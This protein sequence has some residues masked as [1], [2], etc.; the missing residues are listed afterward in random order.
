[1]AGYASGGGP[2]PWQLAMGFRS[3]SIVTTLYRWPTR[4]YPLWSPSHVRTAAL[5]CVVRT[6]LVRACA[7]AVRSPTWRFQIDF[8]RF[9]STLVESARAITYRATTARRVDAR[10]QWILH[11][12]GPSTPVQL[13]M[14]GHDSGLFVFPASF[15]GLSHE[16]SLLYYRHIS[17][18]SVHA[19]CSLLTD[20]SVIILHKRSITASI[21]GSFVVPELSNS[22]LLN[23]CWV[24]VSITLYIVEWRGVLWENWCQNGYFALIRLLCYWALK[25]TA[26]NIIYE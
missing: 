22:A 23:R 21:S 17:D 2:W 5:R 3:L 7:V 18:I 16:V 4:V 24:C 8:S 19:T 10:W 13:V 26:Q 20:S 6:V 15:P 25:T 12:L 14:T 1:M 11:E 9:S